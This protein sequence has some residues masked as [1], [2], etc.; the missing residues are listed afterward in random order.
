MKTKRV[1]TTLAAAALL[2]CTACDLP[3]EANGNAMAA[4][5]AT[6]ASDTGPS[7]TV[8][9]AVRQFENDKLAGCSIVFDAQQHE[10]QVFKRD[11]SISGSVSLF[12]SDAGDLDV[13]MRV[14]LMNQGQRTLPERSFLITD[15]VSNLPEHIQDQPED[16]GE[17]QMSHFRIGPVTGA[18]LATIPKAGFLT[19][20]ALM[21]DGTA[22]KPFKMNTSEGQADKWYECS[23]DLLAPDAG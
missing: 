8:V 21:A 16:T 12:K 17:H 1:P 19:V 10:D 22:I 7:P 5:A 20:G 2:G 18:A 3:A 23:I 11:I 14:H 9:L 15:G 4:Q 6:S 13:L